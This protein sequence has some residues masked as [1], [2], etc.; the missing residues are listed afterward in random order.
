MNGAWHR[1]ETALKRFVVAAHIDPARG[2]GACANPDPA[3]LHGALGTGLT[4]GRPTGL[5]N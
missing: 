2:S 1:R 3:A 4:P 5:R